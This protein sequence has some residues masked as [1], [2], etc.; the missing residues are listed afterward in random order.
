MIC[1]ATLSIQDIL[2]SMEDR[3]MLNSEL[4]IFRSQPRNVRVL[5]SAFM[6]YACVMPVMNI[7]VGSYIMRNSQ[8]VGKVVLYQLMIYTG[9]P[10]TAWINGYLLN[11]LKGAWLYAA[12]MFL[13]GISMFIMTSIKAL[14]NTGIALAGLLMGGALGLFLARNRN[15]L[16]LKSTTDENRNYYQG[17]ESFMATFCGVFSSVA[18]RLG[19]RGLANMVRAR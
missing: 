6:L 16:V 17:L 7:F 13:S 9:I 2:K 5:L 3:I 4:V 10:V 8:D 11:R 1:G 19:H 14:D 18:G 15:Y 12:G